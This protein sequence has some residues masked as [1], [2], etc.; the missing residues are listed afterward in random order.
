MP[1]DT[2]PRYLMGSTVSISSLNMMN[3][4]KSAVKPDPITIC[5][6]L[7]ETYP[8]RT[9]NDIIRDKEPIVW[10][11]TGKWANSTEV[12]REKTDTTAPKRLLVKSEN[13]RS[14]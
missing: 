13:Y 14:L 6:S 3:L 12:K 10:I 7:K 2:Q 9:M 4:F 1:P 5:Y 8:L 11:C